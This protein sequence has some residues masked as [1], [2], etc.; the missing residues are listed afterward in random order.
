MYGIF[1]IEH[2]PYDKDG[3]AQ[4]VLR[5][6]KLN[7]LI[8]QIDETAD[9]LVDNYSKDVKRQNTILI[10]AIKRNKKPEGKLQIAKIK[11]RTDA[12]ISAKIKDIEISRLSNKRK[13]ERE[14][15]NLKLELFNKMSKVVVKNILN[16]S[17]LAYNSPVSDECHD[18]DEMQAEAWIILENCIDKF[19][20]KYCFYFYF[21]KALGRNFYRMFFN[22]VQ[23]KDKHVSY[24]TETLNTSDTYTKGSNHGL[25]LLI[26]QL[27]LNEEEEQV[28][29]SKLR[30]EKKADFLEDNPDFSSGKYYATL[31][32]VKKVIL[33]L[34]ENG[35]L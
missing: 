8:D 15:A 20:P 35:E 32:R 1:N 31:K 13:W 24:S 34:K 11:D 2:T 23:K 29:R 22:T 25:E 7:Q 14:S 5:I 9:R 4:L 19:N 16:Y 28:L 30:N 10:V 18:R 26:E 6:K 33:K 3:A 27:R 21:N 17:N 12:K